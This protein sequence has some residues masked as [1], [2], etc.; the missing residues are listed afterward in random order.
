MANAVTST[1]LETYTRAE[2]VTILENAFKS[3]YGND[4]S[5]ESDSPD[6]QIIQIFAQM[7]VD[8]LDLLRQVYNSFDPDSA[9]GV[10][11]DQRCA[12]NGIERKGGTFSRTNITI[13]TTQALNLFGLNQSVQP[14]YTVSDNDG[15]EW[16]LVTTQTIGSSGTYVYEFQSKVS[17][18]ILTTPNTITNPVTIVLGVSTINNPTAQ[19]LIGVN[20]ETDFEFKTRRQKSVSIASQGYL[21]ALTASLSD[22]SGV[23][24]AKVYENNT[25]ST[26]VDGVPGHSIWAIV[27]GTYANVDVAT[28]IYRK[29]N[30]GCGMFGAVSYD[31]TQIDGSIFE[32]LWDVVSTQECFI[33]VNLQQIDASKILDYAAIRTQIP[34]LYLPTVYEP[35]NINK[36]STIIQSIDDNALVATSGFSFLLAGPYVSLLSPTTK[37]NQIIFTAPKVVLLPILV[38]PSAATVLSTQQVQFSALGGYSTYTWTIHVNNSGASINA[39]SGLYTAGAGTGVDTVRCTDGDSNFT[40]AL[41][42]VV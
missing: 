8:N 3:I 37:K 42:T 5:V 31:I 16:Q 39:S 34:Q 11:L 36:L 18:K 15:N 13:V 12:I 2:L 4:I 40:N 24:Y 23:S 9:I 6:G 21:E 33:E 41:I 25:G 29:R 7:V 27:A 10:V 30:A 20:Q 1:G 32:I 35:V 14:V 19:S 17:G 26:D 28:A 38:T 22:I